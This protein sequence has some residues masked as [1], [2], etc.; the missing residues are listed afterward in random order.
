MQSYTQYNLKNY[1]KDEFKSFII[2]KCNNYSSYK[3]TENIIKLDCIFD[4]LYTNY[5]ES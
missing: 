5:I 3:L 4:Y 1:N 2:N